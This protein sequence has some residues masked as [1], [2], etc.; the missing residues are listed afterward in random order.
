MTPPAEDSRVRPTSDR[1]REALFSILQKWGQGP[2]LDLYAGTGA[3]GLEAW[4]RGYQPVTC[5]ERGEPGWACLVSNAK[6]TAITTLRKDAR[7]LPA[8]AFSGQAVIFLDPPYAEAAMAWND[9]S[10]R[11]R[12]WV[13]P[14]GVVVVETDAKTSLELQTGWKLAE[15]RQYGAPRFHFWIPE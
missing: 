12:G 9:L 14:D 3:V 7:S 10:E 5:V 1:A 4:S 8:S 2:F 15:T 11:L 6:G 13:A